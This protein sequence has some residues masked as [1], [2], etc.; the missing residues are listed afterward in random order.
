M[1][2]PFEESVTDISLN[3]NQK[4]FEK[5]DLLAQSQKNPSQYLKEQ[6]SHNQ[7][8]DYQD[9]MT[10]LKNNLNNLEKLSKHKSELK[11]QFNYPMYESQ[12]STSSKS[13]NHRPGI[14]NRNFVPLKSD[15]SQ[16]YSQKQHHHQMYRLS[17][18]KQ[19][20]MKLT[21]DLSIKDSE[22]PLMDQ[23]KSPNTQQDYSLDYKNSTNGGEQKQLQ[24]KDELNK[25]SLYLVQQTSKN[26]TGN[27]KS[28]LLID[29]SPNIH[30][31]HIQRNSPN[32]YDEFKNHDSPMKKYGQG[33]IY[34][35]FKVVTDED[36]QQKQINTEVNPLKL[37]LNFT[38]NQSPKPMLQSLYAMKNFYTNRNV[39]FLKF[40]QSSNN[41]D[42]QYKYRFNYD[43]FNNRQ[44]MHKRSRSQN[45]HSNANNDAFKQK[46][47]D[48]ISKNS[49][50]EKSALDCHF[51]RQSNYVA[52][53]SFRKDRTL[54]KQRHSNLV[55]KLNSIVFQQGNKP[56]TAQESLNQDL[57]V[58]MNCQPIQK[59][60]R[61]QMLDDQQPILLIPPSLK[62]NTLETFQ[63][64]EIKIPLF[65][66]LDAPSPQNRLT[67]GNPK[68]SI[69]YQADKSPVSSKHTT[70]QLSNRQSR[71]QSLDNQNR[72]IIKQSLSNN[73]NN[74]NTNNFNNASLN[75]N[76]NAS[77]TNNNNHTKQ[78]KSP[79]GR[80][81]SITPLIKRKEQMINVMIMKQ[82]AKSQLKGIRENTGTLK[83]K[84][85]YQR[86]MI[87]NQLDQ[88]KVLENYIVEIRNKQVQDKDEILGVG[89]GYVLPQAVSTQPQILNQT[90]KG[91]NSREILEF[92][93]QKNISKQL[94]GNAAK[95][96]MA[97]IK[98]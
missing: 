81:F 4:T 89:P 73:N 60:I 26:S 75:I 63:Q 9:S 39:N 51:S 56:K 23:E 35:A 24:M 49:L 80:Q 94:K 74:S 97:S 30:N 69:T 92:Q 3:K 53:Q 16:I 38:N 87:S 7:V 84:F 29:I 61:K 88:L 37:N 15:V 98:S 18:G 31:I 55:S 40:F 25:S 95:I 57:S 8:E 66:Q 27:Q 47:F 32:D 65:N 91:I 14:G 33:L 76:N 19:H 21:A 67:I 71:F 86:L 11:N 1:N 28:K 36:E 50:D 45:S 10:D 6:S 54:S 46:L 17:K 34:K 59:N 48:Y 93:V 68:F 83:K 79:I 96:F 85:E 13:K 42:T 52:P 2:V 20:D 41:E 64:Q 43:V 77:V 90:K 82:R 5:N 58:R 12:Y 22:F 44:F 62:R 70:P 72:D 78:E